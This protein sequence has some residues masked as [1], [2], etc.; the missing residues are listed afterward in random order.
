M[1]YVIFDALNDDETEIDER[2]VK[3]TL[4]KIHAELEK[5]FFS[6]MYHPLTPK[7]KEILSKIANNVKNLDFTFREAVNWTELEPNYVSPYIQELLRKGIIN[8]PERGKYR[9]FHKLF[10]EYIKKVTT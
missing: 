2:V 3:R 10:I 4:P 8:K 5:D 6:P 7:A 1:C 9:L